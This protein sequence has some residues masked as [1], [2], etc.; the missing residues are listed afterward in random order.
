[1]ILTI[2]IISYLIGTS[3]LGNSKNKLIITEIA[4]SNDFQFVDKFGDSSPWVEIFND[5]EKPVS[6]LD[7][8]ITIA[9]QERWIFPDVS[10]NSK[11]YLVIWATGKSGVQ[12]YGEIFANFTLEPIP[13]TLKLVAAEGHLVSKI[14]VPKLTLNSSFGVMRGSM[15]KFCHYAVPSPGGENINNCFKGTDLGKPEIS[16][17]S[18]FYQEPLLISFKKTDR[19][20]TLIYTTDGTFPS[21][22]TNPE[23]TKIYSKP[24]LVSSPSK[25]TPN[26]SLIETTSHKLPTVTDSRLYY[27]V[28]PKNEVY[29]DFATPIRVR[30]IDGVESVSILFI[31]RELVRNT[32]PVISI[33]LDPDY[34]F[35]Y[36]NGIYV[37]GKT[38]D[39]WALDQIQQGVD[40]SQIEPWQVSA[41]YNERGLS[42]ERPNLD[43]LN[44]ITFD[45]CE[46]GGECLYQ[47]KIGIRIHGNISRSYSQKSLR[48][49]A[50]KRYGDGSF[51]YNFLENKRD[52][53]QDKYIL[54][55]SGDDNNK[56]LFR[57]GFLQS[58]VSDFQIE[59]QGFRPTVL[60]INGEYWGIHNMRD[61]YDEKFLS[62]K[63]NLDE[64]SLN[65]LD[66]NE[67]A[68]DSSRQAFEEWENFIQGL[69][70]LTKTSSQFEAYVSREIDIESFYDFLI[71][72]IF[73]ANEDS[74]WNNAK[75]WQYSTDNPDPNVAVRDGK[76]RWMVS[77]LDR[78]GFNPEINLMTTRLSAV[79]RDRLKPLDTLHILFNAMM[80]NPQLK[81]LFISRFTDH[82]NF[83]F[84]E[85]RVLAE[86]GVLV[87]MLES[88]IP[89]HRER[90]TKLYEWN[91]N[92]ELLKQFIS[93]RPNW[94]LA[95]LQNRFNLADPVKISIS[96]DSAKSKVYL[97]SNQIP[98]EGSSIF[99][100]Y[101]FPDQELGLW[102]ETL[103]GYEFLYWSGLSSEEKFTN[104]TR[105]ILSSKL[106]IFPVFKKID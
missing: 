103:N 12:D 25:K 71:V 45:F 74:I 30:A 19:K 106:D 10:I 21:L 38:Y 15:R 14:D 35:D 7:Y 94:Q 93:L 18:G 66:V 89:D 91:D 27:G 23:S 72:N 100:G 9:D 51:N 42:W 54:R 59:T 26:L 60:F 37:A 43:F 29:L 40:L 56:L 41:N 95:H 75:W 90:W 102:A 80:E 24:F 4:T 104:P 39:E 83:T 55:N 92:I 6:L 105:V 98:S 82:I 28:P 47:D 31:G 5:S 70:S 78:A 22:E 64:E 2:S 97:N 57:D 44:S 13:F 46:V 67:F 8:S 68:N 48:L 96:V 49:Y 11:E 76:W 52:V 3:F 62:N 73:F 101:Y 32:L 85:S 58:L 86:L 84:N 79:E 88:E 63:Y 77:D 17:S 87:E 20:Q 33:V 16:H 36:E 69:D 53:S 61:Y 50:R 1:M 99:E 65:I 34:L 81:A